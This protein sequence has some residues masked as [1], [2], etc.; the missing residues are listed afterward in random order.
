MPKSGTSR[1]ICPLC[2]NDKLFIGYTAP[3]HFRCDS[4]GVELRDENEEPAMKV[5]SGD[6]A[7]RERPR[8][9]GLPCCAKC[10]HA[11]HDEGECP[12]CVVKKKK[13]EEPHVYKMVV[14][15]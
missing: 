12:F 4:C 1:P 7:M 13:K 10:F 8:M 2:G 5:V 11:P 6:K 3:L 15:S 9:Y 14:K